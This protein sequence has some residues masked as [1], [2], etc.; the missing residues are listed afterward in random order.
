[1]FWLILIN[2]PIKVTLPFKVSAPSSVRV[3]V[4][5]AAPIVNPL[6]V[7]EELMALLTVTERSGDAPRMVNVPE[8]K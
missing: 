3:P 6:A 4:L 5:P 8:F 7:P 1:M 2:S